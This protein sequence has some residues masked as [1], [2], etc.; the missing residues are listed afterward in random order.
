MRQ[1]LAIERRIHDVERR[2]QNMSRF[3]TVT[4]VKFD[5]EKKRWYAKMEQ[6]EGDNET[7]KTNWL[8]WKSFSHGA[9]STSIPPRKGQRVEMRSPNGN[10]EM[11]V[12][13]PYHYN[14]DDPSPH[15]KPDEVFMKVKLPKQEGQ[16]AQSVSEQD[17]K[18][19]TLDIHATKDGATVTIGSTTFHITKDTVTVTTKNAIIN[20]S[21]KIALKTKAYS[22]ECESHTIQAD[23]FVAQTGSVDWSQ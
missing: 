18:D 9:I 14:P 2:L 11:A 10:A 6:G 1:L 20:A 23:T 16:S 8:P 17:Q 15:D 21:D 22:V 12:L 3:G 5:A 7:F 19:Q 13:E 4:D